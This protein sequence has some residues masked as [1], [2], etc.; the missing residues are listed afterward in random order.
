MDWLARY[1]VQLN[2]RINIVELCIPGK[3][4]LK[5]DVRGKLASS[6]LISGIRIRKLLSKGP[7]GYLAFLINTLGDKVNLEDMLIVKD[8]PDVFPEELEFLPP[9]RDIAFKIDVIPG[10]VPIS[11]TPYRMA[12]AELKELKMQ[13]Q[14]LLERDF[15]RESDSPWG[16][17]VLFFKKKNGSLKLLYSKN[18]K[19]HEKHLRIVLQIL[20]EHQLYAKFSKCEFWL[21]EVTF[22]GHIISKDGIKV[23]PVKVEAVSK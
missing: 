9:E 3:A 16:A 22:L 2:C 18:V 17:P 21:R 5:L 7:Q 19:D 1:N 8:F 14:D 12:P 10:V 20:R 11:K 15:I 13:L 4:T 6:A 23:D